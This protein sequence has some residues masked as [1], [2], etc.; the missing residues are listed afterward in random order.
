MSFQLLQDK[1]PADSASPAWSDPAPLPILIFH[2]LQCT[3]CHNTSEHLVIANHGLPHTLVLCWTCS[4]LLPSMK[5][6]V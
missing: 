2:L 5:V 6:P 3:L 1:G 4:F